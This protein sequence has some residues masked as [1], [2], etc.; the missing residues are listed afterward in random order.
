MILLAEL[1]S[2]GFLVPE[3]PLCCGGIDICHILHGHPE[4]RLKISSF[5]VLLC[6]HFIYI[7]IVRC[8]YSGLAMIEGATYSYTVTTVP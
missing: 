1:R 3:I 2:S 6:G 7:Y 8:S 5:R 4:C